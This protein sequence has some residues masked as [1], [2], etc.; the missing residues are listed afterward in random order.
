MRSLLFVLSAILVA[1][2]FAVADTPGNCTYEE[3]KGT[4]IFSVGKVYRTYEEL[5]KNEGDC[6]RFQVVK[7]ASFQLRYPDLVTDEYG[8]DG[9]WTMI[10]NQGFEVVIANRKYFSFSRFEGTMENPI[11]YCNE[12][13][14]GLTHDILQRQWACYRGARQ[15]PVGQGCSKERKLTSNYDD[16]LFRATHMSASLLSSARYLPN[17]DFINKI[18]AVQNNWIATHYPEYE[19]MTLMEMQRREGGRASKHSRPRSAPVSSQLRKL[20]SGLP[21]SFDWR[22]VRGQ[23]FVA[24][25]RN[26][27]SCGSCYSFASAAMLESRIRI[28]SNNTLQP[29]LSPQDVVECSPYSQGCDGGFPYL[30]GGKYAED[31]GFPEESCNPYKGRDGACSTRTNCTR[32]YGTG[33][34]YVGGYYGACNEEVMKL[35]L[36]HQG[37]LAVGFEVY[38]DFRNYRGG[39]YTHTGLVDRFNPFELTNHAVLLV[40]YGVDS[41][42]GMKYWTIKNSWGESW[43]EQGYFRI[44]RGTDECGIE[45]LAVSVQAV[46]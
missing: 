45:S 8:N 12:T 13:M 38:P 19:A 22:N 24:P 15:T 16:L 46:L 4:W 44:R 6:S 33:Y 29:I 23:N 32:Y 27:A 5:K 18:N 7:K 34:H 36:I 39:V 35:T 2:D 21:E 30:I 41:A 17:H 43:G 31:F 3:I 28:A 9:F 20:V 42:T 14:P 37:P 26:Q 40:G 11:S 1:A 25:V 10:Y